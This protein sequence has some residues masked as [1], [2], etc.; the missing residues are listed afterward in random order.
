MPDDDWREVTYNEVFENICHDLE[1]RREEQGFGID[2][3]RRQLEGLY[4]QQGS[5]WTGRGEVA[6]ITLNATVAAFEHTLAEWA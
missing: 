2:E 3:V 5:D 4:I 6:R 1:L